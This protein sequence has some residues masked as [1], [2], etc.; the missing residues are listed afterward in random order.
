[1]SNYNSVIPHPKPLQLDANEHPL[2]R[3]YEPV[4]LDRYPPKNGVEDLRKRSNF[5]EYIPM[6]AFPNDVTVISSDERPRSTWHGFAMT[7]GD[8]SKLYGIVATVWIPLNEKVSGELERQCE[9]WRQNHM[10]TEERELA[11]SLGE[12]LAL[13]RAKLSRLLAKLPHIPQG[14]EE[15]LGH[16]EEIN[17]VEEK[18]GLMTDL[19]RPVRHGAASKIEGLTDGATG[20]W[21]P[22]AY[23]ILGIDVSLTGFW[24]EW[25][26]AVIV[27]MTNGAVLRVPPSSPRIGFWQ[28]LERYVVNLCT[29]APSPISSQTQVEIGIRELRLYARKEALNELPGS[30]NTDLYALFRCLSIPNIIQLFE[31]VLSESRIILLS[32]HTSMLHLASAAIVSLIYPLKWAGVFIPVLP[33]RLIQALDAPCP[34]IVGVER[35]YE[36]MELP[37]EDLVLVDLD[38]NFIEA[39]IPPTQLPRNQRKKLAALLGVAAQHHTRYHV[40]VGPPPYAMETFPNNTF[41][42]ENPSLFGSIPFPTTLS[43]LVSVNSTSYASLESSGASRPLTMNAFLQASY[44]PS[45]GSEQSFSFSGRPA[46]SSTSSRMTAP[47]SPHLSPI[48][49]KFPT[50]PISGSMG[51]SGSPV[52]RTDS[53]LGLP[54]TLRE[55]RSGHFDNGSRRSSSFGVDRVPNRR[56]SVPFLAHNSTPSSSTLNSDF[57]AQSSYAPSVYAQST[58]AA[59][60]IMPGTVFGS[61]FGPNAQFDSGN[62]QFAEGHCFQTSTPAIHLDESSMT[63]GV[64]DEVS[65]DNSV[66]RLMTCRGCSLQVHPRCAGEVSIVCPNA[67]RPDHIRAAFVRC[68]ASL[69]FTY[70]R[71]LQA[72]NPEQKKNGMLY[73][74]NMKDFIEKTP[75]EIRGFLAMLKNTTGTFYKCHSMIIY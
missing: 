67:F 31:Y 22:R 38:E 63:C 6:F 42:S 20:L 61:T 9:E 34:Y 27:P 62:C 51:N 35:R 32:S 29:E 68:F 21:I 33:V 56:P 16:E 19:L 75:G 73:S 69:F 74:F 66:E 13:E 43:T 49:G 70:R 58:L 3:R 39:T 14:T 52:S 47:S 36:N 11:A 72:P 50:T 45:R 23:G 54:A 57:R 7:N 41:C 46:T 55:K 28:P 2:R 48:S 15:R 37:E 65:V 64:C 10:S 59:S 24:K 12:R 40:P 25:L 60:T 1:M 8:G 44:G 30:R 5:P 17:M 71:Y 4:L 18:I 53:G 26:R